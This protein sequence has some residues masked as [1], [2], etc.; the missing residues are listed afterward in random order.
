MRKV[1]VAVGA[2]VVVLA[3]LVVLALWRTPTEVSSSV[4]PDV[5]VLCD[6]PIP[7]EACRSWG[8]AILADGAPS[9]TFEMDDLDRLKLTRGMFGFGSACEAAYFIARELNEA[10]WIDDVSCWD[11]P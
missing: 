10:V 6:S 2:V 9:F 4:R 8:D 5:T 11:S 3:V 1:V 7:D